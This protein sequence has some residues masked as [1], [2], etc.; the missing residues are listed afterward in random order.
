LCKGNAGRERG[1][2]SV[3]LQLPSIEPNEQSNYSEKHSPEEVAAIEWDAVEYHH[4]SNY[5]QPQ[6]YAFVVTVEESANQKQPKEDIE[7]CSG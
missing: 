5:D 6:S 2:H 7:H 3:I 1:T 4:E